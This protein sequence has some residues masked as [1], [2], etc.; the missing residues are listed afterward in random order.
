[1]RVIR[2]SFLLSCLFVLLCFSPSGALT[3][4]AKRI[5][6][7]RA[8]SR[9]TSQHKQEKDSAEPFDVP[10]QGKAFQECVVPQFNRRGSYDEAKCP[11]V[12]IAEHI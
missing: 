12:G 7:F 6:L 8:S 4:L 3:R 9:P 10:W 11:V 2:L 1:M 5:E